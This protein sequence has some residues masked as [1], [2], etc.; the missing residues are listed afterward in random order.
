MKNIIFFIICIILISCGNST[1]YIDPNQAKG[2]GTWGPYEIKRVTKIMVGSLFMHLKSTKSTVLLQVKRLRNRTSEHINTKMI[3]SNIQ[4]HLMKK[5]I[6]FLDDSLDKDAIEQMKQK[7]LGLTDPDHSIPVGKLQS[8]NFYLYG[9]VSG[10]VRYV[11]GKKK[12]YLVVTL[13]LRELATRRIVWQDRKEFL[14]VTSTD[15][16]SY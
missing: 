2:S 12:Q 3:S 15:Q 8:P 4:T 13:R 6:Q 7:Q 5:G 9:N 11:S 16:I 10:N 1:Q 14:K